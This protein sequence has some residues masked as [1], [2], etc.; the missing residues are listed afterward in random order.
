[1]YR[2]TRRLPVLAGAGLALL[3][4]VAGARPAVAAGPSPA[5]P[6]V[7][8]L[9]AEAHI[10]LSAAAQRISWQDAG[11]TA[12]PG[13]AGQLGSAFGG[14]WFDPTSGRLAVGVVRQFH[15]LT[16]PGALT[17]VTRAGLV[18]VT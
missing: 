8:T 4:S 18:G 6:R 17:S 5:D 1:M 15:G 7:T 16:S 9:A 2:R 13:I 12:I 10:P 3:V 14:A 11:M